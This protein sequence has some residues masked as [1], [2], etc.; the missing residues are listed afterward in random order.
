MSGAVDVF[1]LESY[2]SSA[3]APKREPTSTLK[4]PA[5]LPK[6]VAAKAA[7]QPVPA[8]HAPEGARDWQEF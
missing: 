6:R 1:R 7:G 3:A 2:A 5:A 8:G 4:R